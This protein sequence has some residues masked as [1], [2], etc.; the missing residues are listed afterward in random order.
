MVFSDIEYAGKRKQSSRACFLT[1][2]EQALPNG[3]GKRVAC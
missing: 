1:E 2:M 3:C